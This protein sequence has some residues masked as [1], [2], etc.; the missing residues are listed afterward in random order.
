MKTTVLILAV[1][2]WFANAILKEERWSRLSTLGCLMFIALA[3]GSEIQSLGKN[4]DRHAAV[5]EA[6]PVTPATDTVVVVYADEDASEATDGVIF[7]NVE[8]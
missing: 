2:C 4:N 6:R 7:N 5:V 1:I 8:E 3:L